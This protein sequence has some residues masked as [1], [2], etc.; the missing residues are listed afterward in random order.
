[1]SDETPS[2][3]PEFEALVERIRADRDAERA[4][5]DAEFDELVA[6]WCGR[7]KYAPRNLPS[8]DVRDFK[9][10]AAGDK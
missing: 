6:L 7:G 4:R 2:V 3:D 10:A 5:H 1:M 8:V 9:Q